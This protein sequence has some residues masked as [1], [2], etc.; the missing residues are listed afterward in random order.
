MTEERNDALR[1]DNASLLQRWLDRVRDEVESVN[2]KNEQEETS[3][4][5]RERERNKEKEKE[6]LKEGEEKKES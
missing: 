6:K 4:R 1:K 3:F 2:E 5:E